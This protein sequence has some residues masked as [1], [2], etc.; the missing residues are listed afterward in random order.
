MPISSKKEVIKSERPEPSE[1]YGKLRATPK[2]Q[3]QSRRVRPA[4]SLRSSSKAEDSKT[5]LDPDVPIQSRRIIRPTPP[6][7]PSAK[8]Q[9]GKIRPEPSPPFSSKHKVIYIDILTKMFFIFK[10]DKVKLQE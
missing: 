9:D 1:R 7:P 3:I 6:V 8:T 2:V 5:R 10:K 4:F